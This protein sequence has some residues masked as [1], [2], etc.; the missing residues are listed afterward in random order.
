VQANTSPTKIVLLAAVLIVAH[1]LCCTSAIAFMTFSWFGGAIHQDILK[2][3]LAPLGVGSASLKVIGSG[4]NSQDMPFSKKYS[5]CPQNH[6]DDNQIEQ[7]RDYWRGRVDRALA[8]AKNADADKGQCRN[9]LYEFGEGMHTIQDFY[10]HSNY[11][12]WLLKNNKGLEP[13]D[14]GNLPEGICTGYYYY[15]R[16]LDEEAFVSRARSVRGLEKMHAHLSL[17]T[18]EEYEAR[19]STSDYHAALSYALGTGQF[20]HKEL[21]KDSPKTMEGQIVA[22]Q[23]GKSFHQL[24]RELAIADTAR[25]WKALEQKI[26][27]TYGS[28]APKIMAA[29]ISY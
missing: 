6:C 27:Q 5:S 20:M 9:V 28:R 16:P 17:R 29:L 26:N 11:L 14:W 15:K 21:N 24:A 13:V 23:Y 2:K 4:T 10:S 22:P 18:K 1:N 19:K 8:D 3:A 7:G 12:E 25:Q